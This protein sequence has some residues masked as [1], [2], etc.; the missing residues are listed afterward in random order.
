MRSSSIGSD[1]EF[2]TR[3]AHADAASHTQRADV[4]VEFVTFGSGIQQ[5]ASR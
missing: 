4:F 3:L 2:G 5:K 1:A